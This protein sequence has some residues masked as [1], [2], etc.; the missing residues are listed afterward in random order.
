M[1]YCFAVSLLP[2]EVGKK[3]I[4][5]WRCKIKKGSKTRK[6]NLA[7][8]ELMRQDIPPKKWGPKYW[9]M[10]HAAADAAPSKEEMTEAERGAYEKLFDALPYIL[11]C[12]K[13]RKNLKEK[14]DGGWRPSTESRESLRR[15]V[16]DLHNAVNRALGQPELENIDDCANAYTA[17]PPEMVDLQTKYVVAC[18]LLLVIV[19]LLTL[20]L[21]VSSCRSCRR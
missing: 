5:D 2:F 12:T 4:T 21:T 6:V 8:A 10:L 17:P 15:G 11:P 3:I 13:C 20:M 7:L 19:G 16:F 1:F 14:Y 9:A 18:I